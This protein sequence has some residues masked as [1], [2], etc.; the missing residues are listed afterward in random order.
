MLVDD[1]QVVSLEEVE[2][3]LL[4]VLLLLELLLLGVVDDCDLSGWAGGEVGGGGGT[5]FRRGF[6]EGL[7]CWPL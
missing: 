4:L 7:D 1:V 2:G 5:G 3:V 6:G